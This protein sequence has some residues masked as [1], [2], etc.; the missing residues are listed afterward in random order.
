VRRGYNTVP[1]VCNVNTTRDEMKFTTEK[2]T[3][4]IYT[5]ADYGTE[6]V[7]LCTGINDLV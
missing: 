7:T 6:K 4:C 1:Q 5:E 3:L 2:K